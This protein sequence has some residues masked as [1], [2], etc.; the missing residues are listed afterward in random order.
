MRAI[1]IHEHGG[2][3]VLVWE[4]VPDPSPAA[5]E[6]VVAVEYAGVNFVDTYFRSGLYP[7]DLPTTLGSEG[8]GTVLEVAADVVDLTIGERVAWTGIP[9]SYAERVLAPAER[10]VPIPEIMSTDVAGAAML[11]GLTAHYLVN[12]CF[13][14]QAGHN[15]L[16]HAAAGGVGQLLVQMAVARGATVFATVGTDQKAEIA[17]QRGAQ[18]VIN[19]RETNFKDEIEAEIGAHG[20]DVAY[21]GVGKEVF[22]DSLELLT[23]RGTMVQFGNASGPV[24]PLSPLRLSRGGSLYLTRPSL[25]DYIST[26]AELTARAHAV[27]TDIVAGSLEIAIGAR[28]PLAEAADAHDALEGRR[29]TGKVLLE[30]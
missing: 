19:Y 15:V 11:Q 4:E 3:E 23:R 2:S 14:L 12:D 30:A 21:D 17:S 1:R 18:H 29:T 10:L 25:V 27:F 28:F 24:E 16:I 13:G 5:G 6:V 20:I 7:I 26:R 9:G 22:D 8:S